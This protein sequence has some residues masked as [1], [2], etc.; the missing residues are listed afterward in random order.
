MYSLCGKV[1]PACMLYVAIEHYM[2]H[3]L[4]RSTTHV[5]GELSY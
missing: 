2:I 4:H 5:N 3:V 1:F